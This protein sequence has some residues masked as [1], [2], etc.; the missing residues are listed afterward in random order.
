DEEV[1]RF[2]AVVNAALKSKSSFA[3]A[4]IA[5]YTAVLCSP[6]FICLEEKPGPLDD[7][8]LAARLSFFLWNSAPDAALRTL[9]DEGKLH[10][11]T[12]LRA[13]TDRLLNDPKSRR[14]VDAFL[15]YWLDL[16]KMVATAPDSGL[17][18]DY[19]L[20]DL[21]TESAQS[22][23]QLFFNT[24]L[25]D[26]LPASNLVAS[27]FAMLNERLAEH[28]ELPPVSGVSLRRVLLPADSPRGGLMTQASVLKVTANGTTTSPVL[29]GAWIMERILGK[30]PPPPPPSV[31][32]I[33]P[34]TR[35]ATTIREQLDKHRSQESCAACHTKIDPA[36][37]AL[38]NFDVMGGWRKDYRAL[39]DKEPNVGFGHNG[40]PFAFH[41]GPPVDASGLLPDGRKFKDVRDL[42][43][44]LLEDEPQIARN[45]AKQ[46]TVYATGAAVKFSDRDQIEQVLKRASASKYGVRSLVQEVVQSD[47]FRNK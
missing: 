6:G 18:P 25:H 37:F 11:P 4:M 46:L 34:D 10:D 14:F 1:Q 26:N 16:R 17:Y 9:A 36:G 24:L 13:Q 12:V 41:H 40:Q 5:G 45:L 19:Y 33:E 38:E 8:S 7:H 35:G 32:A 47:L 28:Y 42:K 3:D 23:T 21:L 44:L 20:D 29:R 22:E 30:P 39:A 43:K 31:P 2:L 15:D 27:D